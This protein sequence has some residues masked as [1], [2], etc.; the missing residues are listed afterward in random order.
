LGCAVA[1]RNGQPCDDADACT[2]DDAC[3]GLY[4]QGTPVAC[5]GNSACDETSGLCTCALPC[6]GLVCGEDACGN[7]CGDCPGGAA[8]EAGACVFHY[9]PPPYGP[10]EGDTI[11][12]FA[13]LDPSQGQEVR[14]SQFQGQGRLILLVFSAGWCSVCKKDAALF[15]QWV[16]DPAKADLQILEVY[17]E[18]YYMKPATAQ[19]ALAW[20]NGL[21]IN[22]PLLLDNPTL[23][24]E[25]KAS[26]GVLAQ[27]QQPLGPL[28]PGYFP[29]VVLICPGDL[30]ILHLRTG[31]PQNVLL[32]MIDQWLAEPDCT[33]AQ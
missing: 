26:G 10:F 6:L 8:C 27:L 33:K 1:F 14:L 16:G 5:S 4:C 25:G 2:S 12:D 21:S 19:S 9:P 18:D 29:P 17:Y 23:G 7:P 31:F 3:N 15:N 22:Y 20:K 30:R 13:F 11:P 32:P 24:P 28:D